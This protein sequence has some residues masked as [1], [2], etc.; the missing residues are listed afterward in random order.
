MMSN[1]DLLRNLIQLR[2]LK[3][4]NDAMPPSWREKMAA[5]RG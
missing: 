5:P 4:L 3:E 1:R 2:A